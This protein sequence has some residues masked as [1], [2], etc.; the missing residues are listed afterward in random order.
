LTVHAVDLPIDI[1]IIGQQQDAGDAITVRFGIDLFTQRS[2]AI[3]EQIVE[4]YQKESERLTQ[5]LFV[6]TSEIRPDMRNQIAAEADAFNMFAVPINY[7]AT[8]TVTN[9]TQ[10]QT[11]MMILLFGI[12]AV[13]GFVL[14]QVSKAHRK[15]REKNVH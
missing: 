4:D 15:G 14:A 12:C 2:R 3:T 11:W 7:S 9:D 1:G 6:T 8:A 10:I 5:D 13:A